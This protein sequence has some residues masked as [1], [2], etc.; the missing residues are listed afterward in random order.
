MMLCLLPL[1]L[2]RKDPTCILRPD[3]DLGKKRSEAQASMVLRFPTTSQG[4]EV[5]GARVLHFLSADGE[6]EKRGKREK[7]GVSISFLSSTPE[8]GRNLLVFKLG[9]EVEERK[10]GGGGFLH[11]YR[12]KRGC[13]DRGF[14]PHGGKKKGT[15]SL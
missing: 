1:F 8:K 9:D 15:R 13:L 11:L 3:L 6:V 14:Q 2:E 10:R 5:E 4:K 12:E 7:R